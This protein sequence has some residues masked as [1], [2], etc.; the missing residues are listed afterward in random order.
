MLVEMWKTLKEMAKGVIEED[1]LPSDNFAIAI[2]AM[3]L[4]QEAKP[5]VTFGLLAKL[6]F[7]NAMSVSGGTLRVDIVFDVYQNISINNLE[8]KSRSSGNILLRHMTAGQGQTVERN[9]RFFCQ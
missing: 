1:A 7:D 3:T 2:K 8:R 4:V 5:A 9:I 6:L